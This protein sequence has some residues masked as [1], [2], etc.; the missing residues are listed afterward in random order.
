LRELTALTSWRGGV[1]GGALK[2]CC[3][4]E[5]KKG[6]WGKTKDLGGWGKGESGGGIPG[7]E[8]FVVGLGVRQSAETGGHYKVKNV[9]GTATLGG[10]RG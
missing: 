10:F 6:I 7:W 4:V 1:G 5:E 3:N 9:F 8:K 2:R